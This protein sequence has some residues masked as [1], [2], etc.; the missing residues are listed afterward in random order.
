MLRALLIILSLS[1]PAVQAG[2]RLTWVLLPIPGAVNLIHGEI[3]DGMAVE[4][5]RALEPLL[6]GQSVTVRYEVSNLPR[7]QQQF[8]QGRSLCSAATLRSAERDRIG[9]FVP[10]VPLPPLQLVVRQADVVRLPMAAGRVLYEPLLEG[11][12]RGAVQN[13]RVYPLPLR[14]PLR[15]AVAQGRVLEL[16]IAGALDNHLLMLSHGRFDYTL[17]FPLVAAQVMR[18]SNLRDPLGL[19]PLAGLEELELVGTY[20]TRNAWGRSMARRIDGALRQLM[21]EQSLL[22]LYRRWLPEDSYRAYGERIEA[23][24]QQ[25]PRQHLVQE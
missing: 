11:R 6:A 5:L 8:E 17:E 18:E 7:L 4:L 14:E 2:E 10:L 3:H 24:L 19:V 12:L 22:P 16:A 15:R 20:C 1:L 9:Y 13:G 23:Y 21:A 25:R